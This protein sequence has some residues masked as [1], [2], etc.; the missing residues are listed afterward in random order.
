[1][2]YLSDTIEDG[3]PTAAQSLPSPSR[4]IDNTI[5]VGLAVATLTFHLVLNGR[6]GYFRDELYYIACSEHLDWGFVDHPPLIAVV[7][8]FSRRVFGESLHA[9]RFLPAAAGALKVA[10]AGLIARQLGGGR[11]AQAIAALA[12]LT[13]PVYLNIDNILSMNA[14]EPLFWMGCVMVLIRIL[15]GGDPRLWLVFGLLAGL[16]L[17]NK[18]ST[19]FFGVAVIVGL[20]L[21]PA[22]RALK[23]KWIWLGGAVALLIFLPNLIWQMQRGFP[24]LELLRN[25]EATGKNVVLSPVEFIKQQVMIMQWLLFPLWLA[26]LTVFL[27]AKKQKEFRVLGWTYLLLSALFIVFH[28]KNYYLVP[29]YPMLFAGGAIAL[30]KGISRTGMQWLKPAVA[31][32]IVI[33]GAVSA[34]I[35]LPILSPEKFISYE[36][37]LGVK[38][39]NSERSF[40]GSPL[41]QYFSDQF[42]WEEMTAATANVY[43]SLSPEERA[44]AGIFADN[45]GQ[46][47]S[48]DFF[49]PRYGLPKAISGHQNYWYWGPRGYT[50]EILIILGSDGKDLPRLFDKVEA[51]GTVGH[52]Y[53]MPYEHFTI[54]LCRGLKIPMAEAWPRTKHWR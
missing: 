35:V 2:E 5:I 13:V 54:W 11:F 7:T 17:E 20:L 30:E 42:G 33:A 15:Q 37:S 36:R 32:L 9:I 6:Y 50:G 39:G 21:T 38:R 23:D 41:P 22:R 18:H 45:Y 29:I 43:N 27:F 19:L 8:W 47:G 49:G 51:A 25:V 31:L 1:M 46:A 53:S 40:A 3:Q 26:G 14:F 12:V 44:K 48:I 52:P 24:T 28:G 4:F 34:P 16:G 10:L